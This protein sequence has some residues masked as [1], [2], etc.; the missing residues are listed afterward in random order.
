MLA[1]KVGDPRLNP[2]IC[3]KRGLQAA[4][5]TRTGRELRMAKAR[6]GREILYT[7]IN[8]RYVSLGRGP[9]SP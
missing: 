1:G 7:W 8:L 6:E 9:E 5:T 4:T 3:T 2:I